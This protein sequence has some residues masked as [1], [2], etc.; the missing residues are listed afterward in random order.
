MNRELMGSTSVPKH[1]PYASN[2]EFVGPLFSSAS[3]L[4]TNLHYSSISPQGRH[5]N[6]AP[7]ISQSQSFGIPSSLLQ[8]SHSKS[9]Q[10]STSN[11]PMETSGIS[12]HTEFVHNALT[13]SDNLSGGINNQIQEGTINDQIEDLVINDQIHSSTIAAS[14]DLTKQ[15]DWWELN[16]DD[17]KDLLN[18]PVVTEAEQKAVCQSNQEASLTMSADQTHVCPQLPLQS[19]ELCIVTSPLSS[20]SALPRPRMRWTPE[21]H[22]SFVDAVNQLGGSEK[23]T[24]KGVLKLMK[25][26]GLTIYHVKSHLQKYRTARYQPEWADGTS[27]KKASSL[28]KLA[29][30][31]LKT[32]MELTEALRLQ[33][34][35]QKRLHEQLEVQR[36][37]QLRIEEQGRYL[38][39]MFEQQC[40]AGMDRFRP[41]SAPEE[42]ATQ[43]SSTTTVS[44]TRNNASEKALDE[45]E[46]EKP[47]LVGGKQK[48]PDPAAFLGSESPHGKRVKGDQNAS[49][50]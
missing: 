41:P 39:M 26:E 31:D 4:S 16:S 23:A 6:G 18:D 1:T 43:S 27:E 24:P 25:V 7:F 29:S 8:S 36:N 10:A 38:Q 22:E 46:S 45:Q 9:F 15:N 21:L 49:S 32:G 19:G 14:D 5:P 28:D 40:K 2:S 33:I 30:L 3:G 17:W 48:P 47:R 42:Q 37:L 34:E 12:L 50:E 35:V 13:Y 44:P 20:T 11:Y